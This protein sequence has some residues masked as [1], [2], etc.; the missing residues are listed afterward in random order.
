MIITLTTDF[1]LADPYV[2]AV[3]G[4]ILGLNPDAVI[5]DVTHEVRPQAIEQAAFVL[6]G[7]WPYFPPGCVHV[8]V[9]DPGVGTARRAIALETAAGFFI[10]P[11]N[12]VLSAAIP[13]A[14]RE[15]VPDQGGAARLPDGARAF[16]LSDARFHRSPVSA[17][18]H[19]RDVFAPVAAHLS[20]GV[21]VEKLGRRLEEVTLL[22]PFRASEGGPGVL[23]ARVVHIDRFGNAVTTA[24]AEQLASREIV[25]ELRGR[26]VPGLVGA[27]AEASSLAVLTG[28]TGFLEIALGGG[29]AAAVLGAG[30]GD[31]VVIRQ[32]R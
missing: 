26:R 18:F 28:S 16:E 19:A 24:R 12:G 9:V 25:A 20:L 15:G 27:Y 8:A 4:F 17:T 3:K 11:D 5:V 31:R 29:S 32:G 30:I 14:A 23:F 2:S 7:A 21:P 13:D 1:G 10:G 6:T 22:P